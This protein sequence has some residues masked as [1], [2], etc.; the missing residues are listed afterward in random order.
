L[1]EVD[2]DTLTVS[3]SL[4]RRLL[5]DAMPGIERTRLAH[6]V[7]DAELW[8]SELAGHVAIVELSSVADLGNGWRRACDHLL[9]L[10]DYDSDVGFECMADLAGKVLQQLPPG[11][12]VP[13]ATRVRVLCRRSVAL[14]S[15]GRFDEGRRD[16][17]VAY[18]LALRAMDDDLIVHVVH[19]SAIAVLPTVTDEGDWSRALADQWVETPTTTDA[20]R[21][22]VDAVRALH[23]LARRD[24][25][26]GVRVARRA[27]EVARRVG[28]RDL[29][30]DVMVMITNDLLAD[31]SFEAEVLEFAAASRAEGDVYQLVKALLYVFCA[32]MRRQE[33]TFDDPIIHE[34]ELLLQGNVGTSTWMRGALLRI[35]RLVLVGDRAAIAQV[36]AEAAPVFGEQASPVLLRWFTMTILLA[37][38]PDWSRVSS[39]AIVGD[40]ADLRISSPVDALLHRAAQAIGRG[41]APAAVAA[42]GDV[43]SSVFA[44]EGSPL[45]M[46]RLPR[47]ALIVRETGDA[48]LAARM[49]A[50]H[51]DMSGSDLCMLPSLHLGPADAWLAMLADVAGDERAAVLRAAAGRRLA[52]LGAG[53]LDASAA[54]LI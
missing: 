30:W 51:I 26:E 36:L 37:D 45:V 25:E 19:T 11:A 39:L 20:H 54:A 31:W 2:T 43:Q 8:D 10:D 3:H 32:R 24:R 18:R 9:G 49:L 29:M 6:C 35:A 1:V 33:A 38:E 40:P 17:A 21:A 13:V 52:A 44:A 41:D 5:Q 50:L 47:L 4:V 42:L 28:D 34:I 16:H 14:H 7:L 46:F 23:L 15:I 27:I 22:R 53:V 12:E 48:G